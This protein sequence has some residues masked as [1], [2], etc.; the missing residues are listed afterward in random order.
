MDFGF[1]G[2]GADNTSTSD[3]TKNNADGSDSTDL[4]TGNKNNDV[5][6][7]GATDIDSTSDSDD[8]SKGKVAKTTATGAFDNGDDAGKDAGKAKPN[9]DDNN[10]NT[11]D[12]GLTE[13]SV[14]DVGDV[15]YTVDATGNL[16]NKDGS[17]FKEAKDVKD[18]VASFEKVTDGDDKSLSINTIQELVGIEIV[19]DD[20][21]PIEFEN[22][23]AGVKAYIDAVNE[24]NRDEH[25][26]EA[27]NN[28]YNKYPII[29]DVL[30]YYV[31][32]GNSLEGFGEVQDRS[33]ITIDDTNEA[34][35]EQI[36]RTAFKEQ[37]RRGDADSYINYLKSSGTLL[38][39]SKEELKGLQDSDKQVKLELQQAAQEAEEAKIAKLEQYWNG[40]KETIN[41][42][43]IAGYKIPDTIVINKNGQ[44]TSATPN[45][46]Y[47]YIYSV[48]KDGKSQ[49]QKELDKEDVNS[50]KE[51]ELLR[52][53]LKFVGGNY[54]NLVGMAVNKEKV[55]NLKLQ[56]K[57]KTN[58]SIKITKPATTPAKGANVD[59]G[60]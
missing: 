13:G 4:E 53:Y 8:A 22:T 38:E 5:N 48:D 45:D 58:S 40:V 51:D 42:K 44:K 11:D 52:A 32:N 35:Q 27:L 50:R 12:L 24:T 17:I 9:T 20:E 16:L 6:G 1:G 60:Y 2:K 10:T 56:A 23:P 15:S 19:G 39:V 57:T 29:N 14:V 37:N 46:F 18:W 59:F 7:Q 55:N 34:Q 28:L 41:S 31:A 30:N 21:Q 36:I 25:Y 33:T 47:Q 26:E 54:S 49:Y 3:A 43:T